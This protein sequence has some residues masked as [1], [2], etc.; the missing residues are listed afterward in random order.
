[1]YAVEVNLNTTQKTIGQLAVE[2]PNSIRLFDKLGIDYCC[3]GDRSLQEACEEVGIEVQEITKTLEVVPTS[4]APN[5]FSTL[6]L[7]E[8]ITYIVEKHH[9]Y[10]KSEIQRLRLLITKVSDVHASRHPELT[11]LKSRLQELFAELEPHMLKEECVLFPYVTRMQEAIDNQHYLSTPPFRTV[12]NPVRML[13]LEHEG[14]GYLLKQIRKTTSNYAVPEDACQSF[15]ALYQ[16]L[17]EF[18]KDL[19]QH[20]HLENNILFPRAMKMEVGLLS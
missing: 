9:A 12:I 19:H 13:T 1:M 6:P 5:D 14:A 3:E 17:E 2:F 7:N 10:T 18:D 15:T 16:A 20:I 8:L 4:E 11:H